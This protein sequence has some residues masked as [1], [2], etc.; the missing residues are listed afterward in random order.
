MIQSRCCHTCG[1]TFEGGPRAFYCPQCRIARQKHASHTYKKRKRAGHV[2]TLGS[3]DRCAQCGHDYLVT[4]GLQRF[5]PTCAE[6]HRRVHD[7]IRK[8]AYYRAHRHRINIQRN[9][10]RRQGLTHCAECSM[11]F[12]AQGTARKTCSDAH[13]RARINAQ[14]RTHSIQYRKQRWDRKGSQ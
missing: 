1:A 11:P 5:C 14:W 3:H 12:D 6:S 9:A 7:R 4:G 13:R 8:L 10:R 2:R